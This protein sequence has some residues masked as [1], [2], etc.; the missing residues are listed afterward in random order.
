MGLVMDNFVGR[1]T[2]IPIFTLKKKQRSHV[3]ISQWQERRPERRQ[4][5]NYQAS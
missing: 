2:E 4:T 3:E 5:W 1:W